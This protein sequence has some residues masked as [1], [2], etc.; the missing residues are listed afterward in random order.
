MPDS[1]SLPV[2]F[3]GRLE[4]AN[5]NQEQLLLHKWSSPSPEQETILESLQAYN[6]PSTPSHWQTRLDLSK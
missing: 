6:T 2:L 4:R 3:L 5:K 1:C